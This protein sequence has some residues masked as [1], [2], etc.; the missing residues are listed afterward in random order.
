MAVIFTC[1]FPS[2]PWV[3][4]QCVIVVFL[5]QVIFTFFLFTVIISTDNGI[6]TEFFTICI[7]NVLIRV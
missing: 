5:G 1:L 7:H 4:L 6:C 3:G 2:S